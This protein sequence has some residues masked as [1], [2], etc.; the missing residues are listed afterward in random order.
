MWGG[1]SVVSLGSSDIMEQANQFLADQVFLE[2][3]K[4]LD[5]AEDDGI[6]E[7]GGVERM[8]GKGG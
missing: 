7:D 5:G 1:E 6:G 8:G 3:G 4:I 2:Q